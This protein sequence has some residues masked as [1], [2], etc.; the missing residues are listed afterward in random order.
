MI[1]DELQ[2]PIVLTIPKNESGDEYHTKE[3]LIQMLKEQAETIIR[4]K[5]DQRWGR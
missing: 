5:I 1:T 2:L 4:Q 3:Q